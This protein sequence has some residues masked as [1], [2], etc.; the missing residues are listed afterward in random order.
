MSCLLSQYDFCTASEGCGFFFRFRKA[1][2]KSQINDS[3]L[4]G[5]MDQR[6]VSHQGNFSRPRSANIAA[7]LF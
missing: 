2:E 3:N 5:P 6:N 1:V 4:Y 7:L